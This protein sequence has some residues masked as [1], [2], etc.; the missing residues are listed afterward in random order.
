MKASLVHEGGSKGQSLSN[1]GQLDRTVLTYPNQIEAKLLTENESKDFRRYEEILQRGLATFFEVGE[2]L[3]AIRDGRLYR[4]QY[5]SFEAYCQERWKIG[6]SYACRVIGAA[7]RV[8]LL[9]N[10][11]GIPKPEN[12]CQ[13][14]PFLKLAPED[15]P[16]A[17]K[18]VVD[19]AKEGRITASVI[20]KVLEGLSQ[21]HEKRSNGKQ[22]R[23]RVPVGQI[24]MLLYQTKKRITKGETDEA[25][26]DL[27]RI[28]KLLIGGGNP[29]R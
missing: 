17:W 20:Q 28:E 7:Q 10:A 3:T 29:T 27:D 5:K 25:L 21:N 8:K 15:F 16:Q 2:S 11:D 14:R 19:I 13:V 12:E 1:V 22:R 18:C 26:E 24:I 23:P 4:E 9:S 6:R